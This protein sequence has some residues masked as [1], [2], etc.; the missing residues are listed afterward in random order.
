M[1]T[2]TFRLQDSLSSAE[3]HDAEEESIEYEGEEQEDTERTVS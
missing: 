2:L 3:T 1:L